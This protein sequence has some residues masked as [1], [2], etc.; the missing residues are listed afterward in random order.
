MPTSTLPRRSCAADACTEVNP[1]A[2]GNLTLAAREIGS[3]RFW[4][5]APHSRLATADTAEGALKI[6]RCPPY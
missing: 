4:E 6:E 5:P 3:S 2:S 1:V